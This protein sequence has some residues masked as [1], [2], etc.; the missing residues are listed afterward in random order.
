MFSALKP[1]L[2][3]AKQRTALLLISLFYI[4]AGIAHL[5]LVPAFVSITPSW[6]PNPSLVIG[7]TG[8]LEIWGALALYVP[9]LRKLAGLMLALYAVC[10]FPA[11]INHALLDLGFYG[12]PVSDLGPIYHVP[13]LL[14]QPVLVWWA[15]FA[16]GWLSWPFDLKRAVQR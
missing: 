3:N 1:D 13:R 4:I 14:A 6:V 11:N 15:L 5:I 8:V 16:S 12:V 9:S 7:V 2:L 10:V